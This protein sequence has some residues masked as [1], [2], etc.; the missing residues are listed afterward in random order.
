[1]A[2]SHSEDLFLVEIITDGT[3]HVLS[4][5]LPPVQVIGICGLVRT[6]QL[7]CSCFEALLT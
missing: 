2:P 1:M 3:G 5:S 4:C 7:S 6:E